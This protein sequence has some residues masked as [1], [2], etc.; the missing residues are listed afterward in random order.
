MRGRGAAFAPGVGRAGRIAAATRVICDANCCTRRD[1]PRGAALR[2]MPY[3]LTA[4]TT[5]IIVKNIHLSAFLYL[6]YHNTT[7]AVST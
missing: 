4:A 3:L 6:H 2:L 5:V 7:F 1:A